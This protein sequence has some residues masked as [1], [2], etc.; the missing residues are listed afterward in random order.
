MSA[1]GFLGAGDLYIARYVNGAFESWKGPFECTKFEIKP[2]IELK[3][4]T[5]KGKNTYGQVIESVALQQPA[6]LT[7]DL[8]EVNKDSLAIALLGTTAALA[9]AAGSLS[10][11]AVV[12]A[13][14]AWSAAS[15]A[16]W[17]AAPTIVGGAVAASVT[18]A[19]AG[20]TL[21]VSAVSSGTL[22][23][24]Q[25]LSGSGMTAG[26]RI[27]AQLTGT[28]GGVGTY[29]VNNSQT[30]ASGAITGAAGSGTTYVNGVDYIYNADL[31]WVKALAGGAIFDKQPL[32]VSVAYGAIA[33]TEINGAA[34][35]DLRARFKLDGKNQVDQAPVIV[36]VHEVVVAADS[37]F[38]FLADDFNT[39]SMPGRMKTPSGFTSPFTVHL[40][41]A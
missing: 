4:M 32:A 21:T 10:S 24:G 1:R 27:V 3:E 35:A 8:A 29:T 33:G 37:A 40:R 9:Q 6:D 20:T 26:T 31:G 23:V 16:K 2:N 5:S 36:T 30:F 38:D 14:D 39:V 15:K 25:S 28:P 12:A 13:L 34:T 7:V 11:E 18:G 19:I 17:T 41:D 22:S